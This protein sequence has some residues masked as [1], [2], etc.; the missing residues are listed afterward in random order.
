M[1][2]NYIKYYIKKTNHSLAFKELAYPVQASMQE[3]QRIERWHVKY[4]KG[5]LLQRFINKYNKINIKQ[6][7]P[8]WLKAILNCIIRIFRKLKYDRKIK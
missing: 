3:I 2:E 6:S 1:K 8:G 5:S 7:K 4:R